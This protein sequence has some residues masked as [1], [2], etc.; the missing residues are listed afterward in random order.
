MFFLCGH[1]MLWHELGVVLVSLTVIA[2][3]Y[4]SVGHG[5]GSGYLAVLSLT[6]IAV[7]DPMWL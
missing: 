6:T 5:G 3:L 7:S 2:A 4:S 1:P